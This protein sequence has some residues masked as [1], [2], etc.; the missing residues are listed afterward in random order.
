MARN[1]PI[2]T[3]IFGWQIELAEHED[4]RF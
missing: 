3:G 1:L 2:P 4:I